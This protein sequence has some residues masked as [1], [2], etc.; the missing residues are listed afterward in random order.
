MCGIEGGS[1][2]KKY[3]AGVALASMM[4]WTAS[5]QDARSVI[6]DASKAMGVDSL[7]T[8]QYAATGF[9]FAV[10]QAP[11]PA[12]PWPKFIEKSYT[13]SI[14]FEQPASRVDRVRVQG[15]NPPRG[16]GQQ[17]IVGDQT[18]TQTIVVNATTP[19]VQ[20]LE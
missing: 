12:S 16:G 15:E 17:P 10:G 6:G 9:D 13:R 5:A 1:M 4:V 7:K 20:Q 19:W 3:L 2:A 18:Q 8:V 11:N 14:N